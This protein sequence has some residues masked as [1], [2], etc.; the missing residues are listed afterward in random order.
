MINLSI[1]KTLKLASTVFTNAAMRELNDISVLQ[2]QK[3]TYS[4]AKLQHLLNERGLK[5]KAKLNEMAEANH[6]LLSELTADTKDYAAMTKE[7]EEYL[8]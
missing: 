4:E 1:P 8:K 2:K 7:V 6:T 3:N 5:N